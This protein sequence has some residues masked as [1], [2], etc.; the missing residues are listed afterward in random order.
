M[1]AS[2][3]ICEDSYSNKSWAIVAQG[4]FTL[5]EINQMEREMC[6]HLDWE[7][8]V[9]NSTLRNLEATVKRDFSSRSQVS[10]PSYSLQMV[11]KCASASAAPIP[12]PCLF[13]PI[14]IG[15]PNSFPTKSTPQPEIGADSPV[16]I[17]SNITSPASSA[18]PQ[19]PLIS[20]MDDTAKINKINSSPALSIS[21]YMNSVHPLK[22]KM[23]ALALPSVW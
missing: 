4:M 19:T 22:D 1:I 2:K 3:V 21:S 6:H 23:F 7:L 15:D 8:I 5:Q 12:E 13:S 20:L 11:S 14:P 10:Y 18:S 17:Y 9:N 16:P